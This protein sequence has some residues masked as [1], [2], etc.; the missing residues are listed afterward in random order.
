MRDR[1]PHAVTFVAVVK[2]AFGLGQPAHGSGMMSALHTRHR[3]PSAE[4]CCIAPKCAP[5]HALDISLPAKA[6]P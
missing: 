2:H 4:L 6:P 1:R 3:A 5:E